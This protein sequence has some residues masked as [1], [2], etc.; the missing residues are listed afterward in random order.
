MCSGTND[1]LDW[2]AI[3]LLSV[4][5]L[6]DDALSPKFNASSREGPGSILGDMRIV[7][8]GEVRPECDADEDEVE[9]RRMV[10]VAVEA[11]LPD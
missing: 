7:E 8:V 3:G 10:V 11:T 5:T 9:G 1:T 6:Y 4:E 2:A